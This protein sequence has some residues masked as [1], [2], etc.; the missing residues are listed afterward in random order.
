MRFSNLSVS[1]LLDAL[2]SAD[3][4]PGGGTASAIVGAMGAS[5]LVMVTGLTKSKT[6][7]DE[8]K[9]SLAVARGALDPVRTELMRLADADT[10]AF[11]HVMAAYRLPKA[12]DE[13]KGARTVAI[14]AALQTATTTP[15]DTLRWCAEA[16]RHAVAVAASGN[17]SA[18]SD[19]G[20]AIGFLEAAAVGAEANVRINLPS[21]KDEAFKTG[22]A[23]E[24]SRLA[25]DARASTRDARD[26]LAR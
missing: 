3:P 14:Q 13:E 20:V 1:Q 2:S 17:R 8:E 10:E 18:A 23:S 26:Q 5:L 22:A 24:A 21:L 11:D 25:A 4:T 6:N 15:I 12:T 19:V 16:L 7:T 9:A